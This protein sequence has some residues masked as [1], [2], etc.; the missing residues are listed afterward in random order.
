VRGHARTLVVVGIGALVTAGLAGAARHAQPCHPDLQGTRGLTI[1]GEVTG[2]AFA[3]GRV[4]VNWR[5][6]ECAGTS[7]WDFAS[8]PRATASASCEPRAVLGNPGTE[9][10]IVAARANR[11]VRLILAPPS[12]DRPDR[13]DVFD[14]ARRRIASWPL[15]DRPA[16]VALYGG[17]AILSASNRHALYALRIDDG[18]IAMIGI[19]RAGDRPLIGPEGVLYQDDLDASKQRS[20]SQVT[21][22]LVPLATVRRELSDQV[23]VTKPWGYV[24]REASRAGREIRT[25]RINAISMDGP[26]VAFVVHD[27]KGSCDRVL[28]WNIPWHFMSR[29][30]RKVGPTCLPKH[31]PGGIRDVAIAGTRAAWTTEYGGRTRVL[32][33]S[34]VHCREWVAARPSDRVQRVAG[35]SGDEG[36]L[37]YAL[38]WMSRAA[39]HTSSVGLVPRFWRGSELA[40]S[41][42]QVAAV[43]ADSGRV[44]VLYANGTAAVLTRDARLVRHLS[45]ENTGAIALRLNTLAVLGR[46]TLDIYSASSGRRVHVWKVPANATSVDLHYGIALITA[47]RDALA[48]NVDTGRTARLF[49]APGRVAAQLEAPGAAIQFNAGSHGYLRF[50]PMSL[51]E[52]RTR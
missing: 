46:G 28:F 11:L 43:S 4:V 21:L 20:S 2:Y 12:V 37:V 42:R 3:D 32:A 5:R 50:V 23:R 31:A 10:R 40:S 30:T 14:R 51:I 36:V 16:R 7:I 49:H 29:L 45:V 15:I 52:A 26:R 6:A 1:N 47:G 41:T 25:G 13:L 35:L 34:I 48:L 33:A 19:T 8:N 38:G 9:K 17:I 22:K 27:P 24:F 18:R 44:A 39:R